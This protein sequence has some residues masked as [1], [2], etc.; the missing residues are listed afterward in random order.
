MEGMTASQMDW[1]WIGCL[2]SLQKLDVGQIGWGLIGGIL[3]LTRCR[4]LRL[5]RLRFESR[6]YLLPDHFAGKSTQLEL[7]NQVGMRVANLYLPQ[8]CIVQHDA[9]HRQLGTREGRSVRQ[10]TCWLHAHV[11]HRDEQHAGLGV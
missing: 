9:L 10:L 8:G 2:E 11:A 1:C 7:K 5:L 3:S 6:A 4:E